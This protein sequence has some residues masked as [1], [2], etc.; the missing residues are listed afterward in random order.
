MG[1]FDVDPEA[2]GS[3]RQLWED[4]LVVL[5][6]AATQLTGAPT[7][8]FGGDLPG[9]VAGV[10]ASW[11]GTLDEG[12]AAVDDIATNLGYAARGYVLG[13]EAARGEFTTWMEAG[14]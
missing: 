3:A 9:Q 12:A 6:D 14:L 11:R 2:I 1:D 4:E 10:I 7:G 8:G 5:Q 13:D